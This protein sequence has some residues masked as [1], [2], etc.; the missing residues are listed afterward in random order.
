MDRCIV[1]RCLVL[2]CVLGLA[3]NGLRRAA[4]QSCPGDQCSGDFNGDGRVTIDE[5]VAAVKNALDGCPQLSDDEAC[6]DY[7]SAQCSKLDQCVVNG[8]TS[9]YGS[10]EVCRARQKD[11]CLARLSAP[12][13][14]NNPNAVELCTLQLPLGSC[15]DFEL[16]NLSECMAKI[17]TRADGQPCAFSGQCQSSNC[18]IATGTNCGTCAEP[19]KAGD[20][21][22][23][24]SCS[25][26]FACVKATQLCQPRGTLSAN[27]DADHPCGAG[28]SCVTASGA[29]TGT[30]EASGN[31]VGAPC[32]PQ[33][34]TNPGCDPD[35]GLYC[36]DTTH[37]CAAVTYAPAGGQCG[38]VKPM[39]LACTNDSTCFGAEGQTPGL[40]AA[41][42]ADGMACDTQLGPSCLPPAQCVTPSA[43]VTAG[44]CE[45]PN[46]AAC[47]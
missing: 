36:N 37:S 31:S 46:A 40:C 47:G 19:N 8:T 41:N 29:Q 26:G 7:A 12:G 2:V 20:S 11:A 24:A 45:V 39:V 10:V 43:G 15:T 6:T 38:F 28:L 4:A 34:R 25:H 13:T 18:A 30:C 17:G 35:F 1:S 16:G 14:G 5:I 3:P 27:C 21:C 44:T 42:A 23:A 22:A 32:D 9:R 33:H